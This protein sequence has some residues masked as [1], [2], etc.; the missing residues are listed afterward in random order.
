MTCQGIV[1]HHR[2]VSIIMQRDCQVQ[3]QYAEN[4][5]LYT[6]WTFRQKYMYLCITGIPF[7][8]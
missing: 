7:S 1:S 5:W 2:L 6:I 8:L 4:S 3:T